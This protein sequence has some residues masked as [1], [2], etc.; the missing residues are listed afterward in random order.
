MI[1]FQPFE[2]VAFQWVKE[3]YKRHLIKKMSLSNIISYEMMFARLDG[4]PSKKFLNSIRVLIS[5][6]N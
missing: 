4:S 3:F 6:E 2:A 5:H 1:K